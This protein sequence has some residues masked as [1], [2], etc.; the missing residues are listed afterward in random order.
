[1]QGD[2]AL[3]VLMTTSTTIGTIFMT[4]LIAKLLLG[5]IVP[6]DALGIVYSTIQVVLAPIFI[7]LLANR[8]FPKICR[9]VEPACPIIGVIATVVLVGASVAKCAQ[10]RVACG[11]CYGG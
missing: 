9:A 3:S 11:P 2:V 7:G 1:M 8:F 5:T 4:P 6:V 10:V